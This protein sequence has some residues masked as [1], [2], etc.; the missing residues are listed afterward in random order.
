MKNT[1]RR[2]AKATTKPQVPAQDMEV[3]EWWQRELALLPKKTQRL[4]AALMM[5]GTWNIWKARNRCIFDQKLATPTKV[6]QEI[7]VEVN[8]RKSA[9][10]GSVILSFHV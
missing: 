9:C 6:L 1:R 4:K 2:N 7:K 8:C 3:E 5:Y 10:G